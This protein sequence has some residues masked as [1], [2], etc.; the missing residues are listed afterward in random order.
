MMQVP[1]PALFSGGIQK[2][3]VLRRSTRA[4]GWANAFNGIGPARGL[5]VGQAAAANS[6]A[7]DDLSSSAAHQH[8]GP[9]FRRTTSIS[10]FS[11]TPSK[12][13]LWAQPRLGFQGRSPETVGPPRR[14]KSGHALDLRVATPPASEPSPSISPQDRE[15][16]T[17]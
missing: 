4:D 15:G 8:G 1:E 16:D 6:P 5:A 2:R 3:G 7:A 10:A 13:A 9:V 11:R 17:C 12:S 14:T